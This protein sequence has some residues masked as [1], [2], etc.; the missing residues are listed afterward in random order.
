MLDEGARLV[1]RDRLDEQQRIVLVAHGAAPAQKAA[2][3]RIVAGEQP[4]QIT[5]D[6]VLT[7]QVPT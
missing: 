4:D 2:R 6:A 3:S 5:L 1:V 7:F